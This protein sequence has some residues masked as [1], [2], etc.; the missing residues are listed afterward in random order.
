VDADVRRSHLSKWRDSI[1][2][3]DLRHTEKAVAFVIATYM[4]GSG[5]CWPSVATIAYGASLSE[6][7]VRDAVTMLNERGFLDI[8]RSSGR[9]ANR[10]RIPTR[11]HVHGST[12]HLTTTNPAHGAP[13][14][15]RKQ[16]GA[17]QVGRAARTTCPTCGVA[18]GH[19]AAD[20][21]TFA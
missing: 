20:C 4:N 10:Y 21:E 8:D 2:D 9:K 15:N 3:S 18:G 6:R 16:R 17:D 5:I 7:A 11:H 12:R 1:R 13:E 14:S 19:H